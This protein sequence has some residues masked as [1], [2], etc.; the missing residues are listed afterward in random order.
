M[1]LLGLDLETTGFDFKNDYITEIGAVLWDTETQRPERIMSNLVLNEETP[2]LTDE[3]VQ[4]TGITQSMLEAH[5][6]PFELVYRRD[7]MHIAEE[8]D[9]VVAHNAIGFDKPFLT[10]ECNKFGTSMLPHHWIDT[11]VDVPYPDRVKTR[12]LVHLAAEHGFLN[13]FAHR[14]VF[15]VLTMMKVLSQYNIEDVVRLSKEPAVT[16]QALVSYDNRTLASAR[17]YRWKADTKQWLKNLKESQVEKEVK[18]C[19]FATK[20]VQQ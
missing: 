12:K 13:P 1:R 8:A 4:I 14:A 2:Q 18:E 3:I 5:G 20:V 17:G 19:G 15:D 11:S 7:L 6:E 10:E 16:L 9:Y